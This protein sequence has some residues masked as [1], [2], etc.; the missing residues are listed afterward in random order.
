MLR[1]YYTGYPIDGIEIAKDISCEDVPLEI[2]DRKVKKLRTK[3]VAS[4]EVL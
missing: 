4:L 3:D 1:R 2:L